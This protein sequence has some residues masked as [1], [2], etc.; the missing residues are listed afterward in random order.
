MAEAIVIFVIC[1]IFMVGSGF[2][3]KGHKSQGHESKKQ[4]ENHA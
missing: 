4:R 1:G 3:V 2:L